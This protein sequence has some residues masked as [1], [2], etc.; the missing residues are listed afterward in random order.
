MHRDVGREARL[1]KK[2]SL[3]KAMVWGLALSPVVI[4]MHFSE[5]VKDFETW[6]GAIGRVVGVLI[7]GPVFAVIIALIRNALIFR[8]PSKR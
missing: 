8:T 5:Y 6:P 2:W 1:P 7:G 3:R 4:A